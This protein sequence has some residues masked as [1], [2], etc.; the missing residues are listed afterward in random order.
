MEKTLEIHTLWQ[1]YG[2]PPNHEI[3]K[4]SILNPE[5]TVFKWFF[6]FDSFGSFFF[7]SRDSWFM[8]FMILGDSTTI[9]RCNFLEFWLFSGFLKGLVFLRKSR[10]W[11]GISLSIILAIFGL[12]MDILWIT[13]ALWNPLF[14]HGE[15]IY[16]VLAV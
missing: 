12:G 8:D 6:T 14:F 15:L 11:C 3:H 4:F 10:F 16:R 1:I 9:P 5:T 13:W 2:I 7:F